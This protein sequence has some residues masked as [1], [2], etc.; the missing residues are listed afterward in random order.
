MLSTGENAIWDSVNLVV[1]Q[2][3][4]MNIGELRGTTHRVGVESIARQCKRGEVG[5][6]TQEAIWELGDLVAF[7]I[8]LIQIDALAKRTWN[9]CQAI[10][11]VESKARFSC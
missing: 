8:K 3:D 10:V 1:L 4:G 5:Q 9:R 7:H 6:R 11:S 2:V